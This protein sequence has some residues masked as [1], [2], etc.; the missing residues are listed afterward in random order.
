M[1]MIRDAKAALDEVLHH[2]RVPTARGR[3]RRLGAGFEHVGQRAS[4]GFGQL[5]GAPRRALVRY[6]RQR[7]YQKE[8]AVIA[9]RL[10]AQAQPSG[11]VLD[12]HS[13]GQSEQGVEAFD[14][15]KRTAGVGLLKTAL[16]LL[17]RKGTEG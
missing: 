10:C 7:L 8:V 9:S 2:G 15:P 12:A 14:Q 1:R 5:A 13:L 11:D 17:A 16:E 6:T 4:L 3:A